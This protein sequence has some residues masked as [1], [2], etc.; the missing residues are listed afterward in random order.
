MDQNKK[1]QAINQALASLNMD[2]IYLKPEFI[3]DYKKRKLH[4]SS[5]KKR[6]LRR[7]NNA[8]K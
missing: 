8:N 2:Q 3:N 5:N 1:E 6:I 4:I 7:R